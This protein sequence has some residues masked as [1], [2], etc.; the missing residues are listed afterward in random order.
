VKVKFFTPLKRYAV[1]AEITAKNSLLT[2]VF[3]LKEKLSVAKKVQFVTD[4]FWLYYIA[5][6]GL[7]FCEV[8]GL[9]E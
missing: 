2:H 8:F 4:D 5:F 3:F 7:D 1:I 9:F 6:A